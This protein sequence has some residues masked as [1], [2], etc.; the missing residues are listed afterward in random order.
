MC[1]ITQAHAGD[2]PSKGNCVLTL[3]AEPDSVHHSSRSSLSASFS[4]VFQS[5]LMIMKKASTGILGLRKFGKRDKGAQTIDHVLSNRYAKSSEIG[6]M[7]IL[8]QTEQVF[9][10]DMASFVKII[11]EHCLQTENVMNLLELV[12]SMQ[13]TSGVITESH[14]N[15]KSEWPWKNTTA[16]YNR[17]FG[18]M[19][20][21]TKPESDVF[22]RSKKA[23]LRLEAA[24]LQVCV[25]SLSSCCC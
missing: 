6:P 15:I 24:L 18:L 5:G 21:F 2:I 8:K 1:M 10:A 19:T 25:L 23:G 20:A 16:T 3:A 4:Q 11:K 14:S 12:A 7:E 9:Q 17:F 22:F 13:Q